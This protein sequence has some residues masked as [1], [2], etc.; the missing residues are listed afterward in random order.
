MHGDEE[1]DT[2]GEA[3][4]PEGAAGREAEADDRPPSRE[5][6]PR[7][8][9]AG[10]AGAETRRRGGARTRGAQP[11]AALRDREEAGH[12]GPLEDGQVGSDRR[13]PQGSIV[14]DAFGTQS[15][16]SRTTSVA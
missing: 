10:A 15:A 7:P 14:R 13:D 11:L 3:E 8:A 2:G 12:P 1:A 16:Q 4:H 5:H 9:A 6:A